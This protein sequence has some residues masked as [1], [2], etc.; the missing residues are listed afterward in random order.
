MANVMASA[1]AFCGCTALGMMA[2][3]RKL[4][5]AQ[6]LKELAVM[7][8]QLQTSTGMLAQPIHEALEEIAPQ[9]GA[10][11]QLAADA[12]HQLKQGGQSLEAVWA[13][14]ISHTKDRLTMLNP[15]D[16]ALLKSMGGLLSAETLHQQQEQL[17][18]LYQTASQ[19]A[20]QAE[21][22]RASM[23]PLYQKIGI[24]AGL[25]LAVAVV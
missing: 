19:H 16:M 17:A 7:V 5:R 21:Q 22:E 1:A 14:S 9:S 13:Q 25:A 23:A 3:S 4:K 2:S 11:G 12:A 24:L 10:L 18:R 20:E 6:A 8:Q 15:R